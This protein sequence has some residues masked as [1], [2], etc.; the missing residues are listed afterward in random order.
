MQLLIQIKN[1]GK[2]EEEHDYLEKH[3]HGNLENTSGENGMLSLYLVYIHRFL[4][5]WS[6]SSI[7]VMAF[8]NRGLY[9]ILRKVL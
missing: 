4:L 9:T 7:E 2:V 6:F 1:E 3:E 8:P 5:L